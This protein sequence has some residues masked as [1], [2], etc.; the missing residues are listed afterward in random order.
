MDTREAGASPGV[1]EEEGGDPLPTW[2][3]SAPGAACPNTWQ[4]CQQNPSPPQAS[5]LAHHFF[6]VSDKHP[7][8]P[9]LSQKKAS[10]AAEIPLLWYVQPGEWDFKNMCGGGEAQEEQNQSTTSLNIAPLHPCESPVS[11]SR[12]HFPRSTGLC[13]VLLAACKSARGWGL[14]LGRGGLCLHR[15]RRPLHFLGQEFRL[16]R[17]K[18]P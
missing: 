18:L 15:L 12:D 6:V 8:Q 10:G 4:G 1:A 9:L 13:Q 2:T 14:V 16:S 7:L 17:L 5:L 3:R 11:H